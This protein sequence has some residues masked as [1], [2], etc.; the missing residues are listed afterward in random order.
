MGEETDIEISSNFIKFIQPAGDGAGVWLC[1]HFT[2]S[3]PKYCRWSDWVPCL[4]PTYYDWHADSR[5][6][7]LYPFAVLMQANPYKSLY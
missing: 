7:G 6:A 5:G 3:P 2:T 4:E 1:S